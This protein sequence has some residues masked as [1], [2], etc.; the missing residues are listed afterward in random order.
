MRISNKPAFGLR[1][2]SP[3]KAGQAGKTASLSMGSKDGR[4][5]DLLL[6]F[7]KAPQAPTSGMVSFNAKV[8]LPSGQ[9]PFL[10][11]VELL[12]DFGIDAGSFSKSDTQQGINSLSQGALGE[13]NHKV[14][15]DSAPRSVL[16]DLKGHVSLKNGIATFSNLS[17]GVPRR[18]GADAGNLQFDQRELI[19]MER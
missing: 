16:S 18:I 11:K 2:L 4:I 1:A 5:Q 9:K 6:L 3:G 12:G 13:K 15:D 7:T 10:K 14:D 8:S 19:F 17:F